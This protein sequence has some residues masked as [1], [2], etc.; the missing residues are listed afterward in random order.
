M[1]Y[2]HISS[3]DGPGKS[4]QQAC[5]TLEHL[6][7]VAQ[8]AFCAATA[9]M[10]PDQAGQVD[11]K[12]IN[13]DIRQLSLMLLYACGPELENTTLHRPARCRSCRS[14]C[15]AACA[16]PTWI[17]SYLA[18]AFPTL[19]LDARPYSTFSFL[20]AQHRTLCSYAE[21]KT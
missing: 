3:T 10:A 20:L 8:Y 7:V 1:D 12:P 4:L 18:T 6:V 11:L 19:G 5:N 15:K 14:T 13:V 2:D 9:A 21:P 16:L 17:C